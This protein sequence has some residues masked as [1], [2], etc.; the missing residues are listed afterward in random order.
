MKVKTQKANASLADMAMD[1]K[2]VRIDNNTKLITDD[3]GRRLTLLLLVM[4]SLRAMTKLMPSMDCKR[5]SVLQF[6]DI[7]DRGN[8]WIWN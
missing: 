6:H 7:K 1:D 2:S 8:K 3:E 5:L 4:S